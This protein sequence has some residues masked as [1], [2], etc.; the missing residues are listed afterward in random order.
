MQ[1]TGWGL[2]AIL[3]GCVWACS[4]Q[5]SEIEVAGVAAGQAGQAGSGDVAS[6]GEGGASGASGAGGASGEGL[7]GAAGAGGEAGADG[8][9]VPSFP[10]VD[11]YALWDCATGERPAGAAGAPASWPLATSAEATMP[12]LVGDWAHNG[13]IHNMGDIESFHFDLDGAGSQT[14][15][16]LT[17]EP[18]QE[19]TRYAGTIALADHVITLDSSA[20]TWD[21]GAYRGAGEESVSLHKDLPHQVIRY[22]Y[23]YVQATDALYV[24]TDLCTEP[25]RFWRVKLD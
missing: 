18:D 10:P 6:A 21:Y 15:V 3:A 19:T 2:V 8:E 14:T 9:L 4:E 11:E 22:G 23:S 24:N 13:A 1:K 16:T 12:Q 17:S 25:V 5:A 20:G 7:G